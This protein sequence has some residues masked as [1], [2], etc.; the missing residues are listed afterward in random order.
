MSADLSPARLMILARGL[1]AAA[2]EM[3]ANLV[4]SAFSPVVREARDCSCALL[5]AQGR[6]VAQA[7]MIPLQT[8]AL[9][10]SFAAAAAQLDLSDPRP[11]QAVILND[12]YS[13]GQ[14]LN[15]I[16]VFTPILHEG[17][18]LGWAGST[19]HHLDIGGGAPGVNSAARDLIGEGLVIPP[20]L[21]DVDR[22]WRGGMV[23]RLIFANI[24][25][26][27]I[28]R[29][30]MDAQFAAN[31]VGTRRVLEMAER[32]GPA[33]VHAAMTEVLDYSER[34]MRAGIAALPDGE[35]TGEAWLDSD[36][37]APGSPPVRI[38]ARVRIEGDEAEIDFAGSAPEARSMFNSTF[39]S[40]M[41]AAVT[42]LRS[43]L[44]DLEMPANDGCNR[45][46]KVHLPEGSLLHPS[47]GLPVRA[48]ATAACR[49][50]DAVHDALG[51]CVPE[52]I[53]AQGMN[54]TTGFFLSRRRPGGFDLHL[55]IVGGGW[56][57]A[58][59]YDAIHATD[60]VLSSCR[61]TP[62]E[63]IEQV[64]PHLRME[65]T[66]L[67]PGSFGPGRFIGGMGIYRRYAILSD[68]VSLSIYSD[69]FVRPP[70]GREGGR[71]GALASLTVT[72]EGEAIALPGYGTFEL[73]PGDVVELRLP[74]G[75]GWGDPALR[76]RA[77]LARDL[78]DG[79]VLDPAPYATDPAR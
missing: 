29:G 71:D 32:F 33:A 59:G 20:L 73:R 28:G 39:A 61:L 3:G 50:L 37:S 75:G 38:R 54:A 62:V 27:T 10:H 47:P 36:G 78:E 56:G 41:A 23:E 8:A 1:Q 49:A 15:D 21:I 7:E 14:H 65:A 26:P 52:R 68:D 60:H 72:R 19:A 13:G 74:G 44:G 35:W 70:R 58:M 53:P 48:R 18:L 57:A 43:A 31:H 9:N 77:A 34:R 17:E 69:R 5:D 46:L 42:A 30:D 66:G 6:V 4:R 67:I 76:D 22:D 63:A 25:T 64:S 12:P 11:G 40:S 2:D 45:P 55:D 16:I 51:K 79:L 24:R